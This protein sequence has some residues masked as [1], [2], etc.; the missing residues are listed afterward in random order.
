MFA[1]LARTAKKELTDND[2]QTALMHASCAGR[3]EVVRLLLRRG[4]GKDLT[5]YDGHLA[6]SINWGGG[7][8]VWGLC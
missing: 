4:A 3:A 5:D 1:G 7:S 6:V 8:F 2:G